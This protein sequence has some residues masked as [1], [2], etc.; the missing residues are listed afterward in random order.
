[1]IILKRENIVL[2][3]KIASKSSGL[4]WIR[5]GGD[6]L[7]FDKKNINQAVEE[8]LKR[9]QTDY[10]DLY[11]LHWPERT[12]PIFGELDFAY[13]PYDTSW[14][15][16]EEVLENLNYRDIKI[17]FN[18]IILK[19]EVDKPEFKLLMEMKK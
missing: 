11:Q 15:P 19:N 8:S 18:S 10:I 6:K 4:E 7:G 17:I 9:L 3:S 1:M 14:I 5:K 12:V 13:D 2:A 16:F